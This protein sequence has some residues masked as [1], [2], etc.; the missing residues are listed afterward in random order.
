M[1]RDF[2]IP[3]SIIER[4][5]KQKIIKCKKCL[6]NTINQLDLITLPNNSR[7]YIPLIFT[8]QDHPVGHKRSLSNLK[9]MQSK[10]VL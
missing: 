4:T 1:I 10:Y 9:G 8:K 7:T 6:K 5:S 3:L 2:N